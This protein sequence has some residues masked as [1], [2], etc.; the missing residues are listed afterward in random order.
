MNEKLMRVL[1]TGANGQLGY[2]LQKTAAAFSAKTDFA[3]QLIALTRAE[4]DLAQPETLTALL[5]QYKP[6]AIINA[7]AYTAVDKAETDQLQANT[8]N[9]LAVAVIARWCEANQVPLIQVSTDFVFD[10]KKSSPYLPEDQTNP[11]GIYGQTKCA[12]EQAALENCSTGY[13]VRTGWVYCEQGNN[14]V[15]AMLRLGAER[16]VLGVVADQIGTPTYAVNLAQMIWQLLEQRPK[17]K[18]FHFSDAGVASWYDFAVA[19]FAEAKRVGLIE[20]MPQVNPIAT[21]DYPTPAQRPAYSVLD[22]R[23]TWGLLGIAPCYWRDALSN[24][25][26]AYKKQRT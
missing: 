8:I 11:L 10:G 4:F 5:N 13:V 21:S 17:Q 18:L 15:K 6:D 9:A 26:D 20:K 14:F 25:L 23:Q 22:K 12:G 19:I 16:D 24:M 2:A 1:I 7:A 3:L